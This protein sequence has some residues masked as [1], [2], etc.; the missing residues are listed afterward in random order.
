MRFQGPLQMYLVIKN[1]Q[2]LMNS[3]Y[4]GDHFIPYSIE[5]I[6]VKKE[7][8]E[9]QKLSEKLDFNSLAYS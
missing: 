5:N 7:E 9:W 4:I 6:C 3:F 2:K 8:G 1:H